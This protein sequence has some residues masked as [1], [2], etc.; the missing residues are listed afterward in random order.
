MLL[1]ISFPG[2]V[3]VDATINGHTVRTD[4][5]AP[6]GSA[7][8]MT[9]FDLFFASIGTCAGFYALRFCQERGIATEGL[10]LSVEPVRDPVRKRVGTVRMLLRLPDAFPEKYEE[11]ILRAIDQCSVKRHVLEAPAFEVAVERAATAGPA[12]GER[13]FTLIGATGTSA[14]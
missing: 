6:L 8:A 10:G 2:G 1:T 5:L 7:E 4:Q 14:P 3:A 12:S 13:G 9:P 11:A